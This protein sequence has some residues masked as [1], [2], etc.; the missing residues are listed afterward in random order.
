[1]VLMSTQARSR[2]VCYLAFK[3]RHPAWA[4]SFGTERHISTGATLRFR[5]SDKT[6]RLRP[7]HVA[8]ERGQAY[9]PEVPVK[10]RE[11]IGPALASPDLV[12]GVVGIT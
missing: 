6:S 9:E 2:W 12:Y 3:H 10:V 8:T 4:A 5:L 1:M 7:R 11:W